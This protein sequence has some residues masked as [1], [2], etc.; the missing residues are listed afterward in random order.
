MTVAKMYFICLVIVAVLLLL[1]FFQGELARAENI[2]VDNNPIGQVGAVKDFPM[3]NGV[4]V[5][6]KGDSIYLRASKTPYSDI[7]VQIPDIVIKKTGDGTATIKPTETTGSTYCIIQRADNLTLDGITLDQTEAD[8]QADH[9]GVYQDW[10]ATGL[11]IKG[12][13]IKG[14][15]T[16]QYTKNQTSRKQL[17]FDHIA[18]SDN[19]TYSKITVDKTS[20]TNVVGDKP[21]Y[22]EKADTDSTIVTTDSSISAAE[23]ER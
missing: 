9:F 18:V 10:G 4:L 13:E 3:K 20:F 2:I 22:E 1:A 12:G 16:A 15:P 11:I 5:A 8:G 14:P 21:S 23:S 17:G 19:V 6:A 7:I